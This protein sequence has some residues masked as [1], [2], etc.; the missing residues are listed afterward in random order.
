M[1]ELVF[2]VC[3]DWCWCVLPV[4]TPRR[5]WGW[6]AAVPP[7]PRL[8]CTTQ[9]TWNKNFRNSD[10]AY[11]GEGSRAGAGIVFITVGLHTSDTCH[12]SG[13]NLLFYIHIY[14][15]IYYFH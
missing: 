3:A 12:K 8:G 5:D 6:S 4:R 2:T 9:Q 11:R 10:A 13:S 15:N 7:G 1:L 14:F